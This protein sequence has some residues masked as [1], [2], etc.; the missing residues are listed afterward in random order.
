M[1]SLFEILIGISIVWSIFSSIKSNKKK[2][3]QRNNQNKQ[4]EPVRHYDDLFSE[5]ASALGERAPDEPKSTNFIQEQYNQSPNERAES[6]AKTHP[7]HL[8]PTHSKRGF[9]AK[10]PSKRFSTNS[11]LDKVKID[12]EYATSIDHEHFDI[13]IK[14]IH[15][16]EEPIAVEKKEY[17]TG[18]D[19]LKLL[20]PH[21][22]AETMILTEVLNKPIALRQK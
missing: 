22:L 21:S 18:V 9:A 13:S 4:A 5:L 15:P 14:E 8:F 10:A 1:D 3:E 6:E 11:R 7:Q 2:L 20:S 12:D 19:I 16:L 17:A